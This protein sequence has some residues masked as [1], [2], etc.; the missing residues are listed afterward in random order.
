MGPNQDNNRPPDDVVMDAQRRLEVSPLLQVIERP[1]GRGYLLIN[2]SRFSPVRLEG[3]RAE[4]AGFIDRLKQRGGEDLEAEELEFLASHNILVSPS[5]EQREPNDGFEDRR[6][7]RALGQFTIRIAAQAG[8]LERIPQSLKQLFDSLQPGEQSDEP[9]AINLKVVCSGPHAQDLVPSL[10]HIIDVASAQQAQTAEVTYFCEL[11]ICVLPQTVDDLKMLTRPSVRINCVVP[12]ALTADER[13]ALCVLVDEGFRP[14][15]VFHVLAGQGQ[16]VAG[17]IEAL[18]D[19]LGPDAFSWAIVPP[20][21]HDVESDRALQASLPETGDM[22]ALCD[23]CHSLRNVDLAQSWL[24]RDLHE[25]VTKPGYVYPCRA[26]AGRAAFVDDEGTWSTCHLRAAAEPSR[27][28]QSVSAL[29]NAAED[30]PF[31]GSRFADERC[32]QCAVRFSCG[33]V[34]PYAAWGVSDPAVEIQVFELYCAMRKHMI[35]QFFEDATAPAP[36]DSGQRPAYRFV[37]GQGRL[38]LQPTGGS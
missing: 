26:C 32:G 6:R 2:S 29:L 1:N 14:H 12:D 38:E 19:D 8:R 4:V 3:P 20:Y 30:S 11:P 24:C 17:T 33:G 23:A 16:Q 27:R 34:C 18:A 37:S 36:S 13:D 7:R 5:A 10:R 15:C 21:R 28:C 31:G 35:L 9:P 22:L 25:R